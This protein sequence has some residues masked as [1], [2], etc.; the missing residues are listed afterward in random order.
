LHYTELRIGM[1]KNWHLWRWL[2]LAVILFGIMMAM[3]LPVLSG[4]SN[5]SDFEWPSVGLRFL[6]FALI[7]F[8]AFGL[9]MAVKFARTI[10][11]LLPAGCSLGA[12]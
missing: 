4:S 12:R 7:C 1:N 8:F 10:C 5:S 6:D 11:E 9:L 2:A 3:F